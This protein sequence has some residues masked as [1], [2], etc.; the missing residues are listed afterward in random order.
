MITEHENKI[1]Y[2][3]TDPNWIC[4]WIVTRSSSI[5]YRSLSIFKDSNEI[6]PTDIDNVI[7]MDTIIPRLFDEVQSTVLKWIED[8]DVYAHKLLEPN[9]IPSYLAYIQYILGKK[10]HTK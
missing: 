9:N 10:F 2:S 7:Y 1:H 6:D 8:G 3:I 4:E 5:F